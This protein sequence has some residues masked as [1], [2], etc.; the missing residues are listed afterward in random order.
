[1][2]YLRIIPMFLFVLVLYNI[3]AMFGVVMGAPLFEI[4]LFSGDIWGPTTGDLLMVVGIIT[5]YIE[6]VKSTSSDATAIIDHTLSVFVFI[7]FLV[8]FLVMKGTATSTF[9]MLMLMSLLDVVAG[10][11]I[12]VSSARRDMSFHN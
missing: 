5:L 2:Q 3:L 7:G 11:T 1:M 9:V 12:T 8:E 10:F 6:L 4:Q